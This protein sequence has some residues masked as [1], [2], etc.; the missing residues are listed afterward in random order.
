M[1]NEQLLNNAGADKMRTCHKA[2]INTSSST[3]WH[4]VTVCTLKWKRQQRSVT[5]ADPGVFES[6][7]RSDPFGGVDRQHLIDQILGLRGHRVPLWRWKLNEGWRGGMRRM[8]PVLKS[9]WSNLFLNNRVGVQAFIFAVF[10]RRLSFLLLFWPEGIHS[11]AH[12]H[13]TLLN[14]AS[15]VVS[16]CVAKDR[17]QSTVYAWHW[18]HSRGAHYN[19]C[20]YH[21]I[22]GLLL[23]T[24][25]RC[26]CCIMEMNTG[27]KFLYLKGLRRD[28]INR[29]MALV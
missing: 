17:I 2:A 7:V 14:I 5:Y 9:L 15:T 27:N 26:G 16:Y 18:W 10:V 22:S 12:Y 6:L 29:H 11:E 21:F 1:H 4:I 25:I 13:Y 3:I 24:F 28:V 8:Q 20:H 23:C 19:K